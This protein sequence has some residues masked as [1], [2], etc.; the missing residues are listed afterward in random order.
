MAMTR[1]GRY[2]VV[3]ELGRGAMGV[4]YEA[5]DPSIGRSVAIKTI[6]IND[7]QDLVQRQ[8]LRE[9]LFREARS[10][11]VLSHP[12]IVTIYDM[13]E[14]DGFAWVAMAHVK[15]PTLE[16]ILAT[17]P[18]ITGVQMLRMLRQVA[19]A[20]DYAHSRGIIHRDIKPANIMADEDGIVKITDFGIAKI[21]GGDATETRTIAGTPNYMSP[22]QVQGHPVDGRS[23][24]FSL[25]VIV[26]EMLTGERP[27]Q[28][29]QLSN[30]VYKIVAE[31][32][33]PPSRINSTLSP[34]ID[35]VLA[36]VL[37]K[38]PAN[39][40]DS[41]LAFV[42][43]LEMACGSSHGWKPIAPGT[44]AALPT[45]AIPTEKRKEREPWK[46]NEK[47]PERA[48]EKV[49]ERA[50]EQGNGRTPE[51]T[52]WL[53][54]DTA[55]LL[56]PLPNRN[57][58]QE[59]VP[60]HRRGSIFIPIFLGVLVLLASAGAVAW[61]AGLIPDNLTTEIQEAFHDAFSNPNTAPTPHRAL[62][63]GPPDIPPEV[64]LPPAKPSPLSPLAADAAPP[65]SDVAAAPVASSGLQ[66]LWVTTNPP[67]AK[68]VLDDSLST[69]CQ[70]PCML[71]SPQGVHHLTASQAG[72]M[73]E[74]REVQVGS[75]AMDVPLITLRQP[76]GTLLVSSD[77]PG[78][79]V[80]INGQMQ[81]QKTPA[82]INL[83]AGDYMVTVERGGRTQ[84]QHVEIHD[85]PVLLR[86][87]IGQ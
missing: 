18:P 22:E 67:G 51:K 40:F 85:S 80:V 4:V 68:V 35:H 62:Q 31:D 34:A 3:G 49:N 10:A 72:Y 20:L 45:S 26:Y 25:A 84:S 59:A 38:N 14:V 44:A 55:P 1:I 70:S 75:T 39:R 58:A 23:D 7:F 43:A 33:V 86:F 52:P 41:C 76:G 48:P 57:R 69:A 71:H 24:Q 9:R 17:P 27:F 32:P 87:P 60:A 19:T 21:T 28:G 79:S 77:P 30:I 11:G 8:K 53:P 16:K 15:G 13:D 61:Q 65:A 73:N 12:N 37:E 2:Q 74:Y 29:E 78:A 63:T 46:G 47:A 6:R 82:S 50:P 5:I 42:A 36:R 81:T 54:A 64:Q 66:E 56:P 83:K